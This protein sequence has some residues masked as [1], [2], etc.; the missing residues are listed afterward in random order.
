[1]IKIYYFLLSFQKSI[2]ILSVAQVY[3]LSYLGGRDQEDSDSRPA[4]AKSKTI[5]QKYPT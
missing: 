2:T 1:M 4:R 3:N 5:F